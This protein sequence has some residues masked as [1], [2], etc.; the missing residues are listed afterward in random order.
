MCNTHTINLAY[1]HQDNFL[2]RKQEK[3]E[4]ILE[5]QEKFPNVLEAKNTKFTPI[6]N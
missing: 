3:D 5:K 2:K 4:Y 1:F 6:S